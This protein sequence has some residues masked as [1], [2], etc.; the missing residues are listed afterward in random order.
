[1]LQTS[2]HFYF[3]NSQHSLRSIILTRTENTFENSTLIG[4]ISKQASNNTHGCINN[5]ASFYRKEG[6]Q[7]R[8]RFTSFSGTLKSLPIVLAGKD[9][10]LETVDCPFTCNYIIFPDQ[11]QRE[12]EI[13]RHKRQSLYLH[14]HQEQQHIALLVKSMSC[15]FIS[16]NNQIST[17]YMNNVFLNNNRNEMYLIK[18]PLL[19]IGSVENRIHPCLVHL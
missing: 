7:M 2:N 3:R 5:D 16:V 10:L 6:H 17:H 12:R 15:L 19:K 14:F 4:S 1:M 8:I 9:I 18:V 13:H 11:P